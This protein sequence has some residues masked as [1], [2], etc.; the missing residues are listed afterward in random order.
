MRLFITT[1]FLLYGPGALAAGL[2]GDLIKPM[3]GRIISLVGDAAKGAAEAFGKEAYEKLTSGRPI[4]TKSF[5]EDTGKRRFVRRYTVS[6]KGMTACNVSPSTI[7]Q[8]SAVDGTWQC[9]PSTGKCTYTGYDANP[10]GSDEHRKNRDHKYMALLSDES[11]SMGTPV[12]TQYY[13]PHK[14]KQLVLWAN[15]NAQ[16]GEGS[17]TVSLLCEDGT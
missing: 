17:L 16:K 11:S 8:V 12:V 1:L 3:G 15:D 6:C 10:H 2:V 13:I 7:L 4:E 5:A 14:R 9:C